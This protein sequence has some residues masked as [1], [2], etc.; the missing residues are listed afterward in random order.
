MMY[1]DVFADGLLTFAASYRQSYHDPKKK[2]D[3]KVEVS[4]SA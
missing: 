3:V 2:I 1:N 4:L